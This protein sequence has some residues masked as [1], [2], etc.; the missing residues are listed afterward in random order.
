MW[1]VITHPCSN[2]NGCLTD[3]SL[4]LGHRWVL[5]IP[6]FKPIKVEPEAIIFICFPA[7]TFRPPSQ[8]KGRLSRYGDFYVKDKTVA[9][10]F[11]LLH[12]DPYTDKTTSLYWDGHHASRNS[13][14]G[15]AP[16]LLNTML[17]SSQF[18]HEKFQCIKKKPVN[19]IIWPVYH[20]T[21]WYYSDAIYMGCNIIFR[22]RLWSQNLYTQLSTFVNQIRHKC[23]QYFQHYLH[24]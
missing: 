6:L 8:W 3:S 16:A 7:I 1:D 13:F 15:P 11:C 2:F 23:I 24:I 19:L 22:S 14:R 10:P 9:R 20:L 5:Q 4:M 18:S 12:G 17:F 21:D